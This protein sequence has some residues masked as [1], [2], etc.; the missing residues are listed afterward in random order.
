MFLPKLHPN[1]QSALKIVFATLLLV[2]G[3]VALLHFA[4]HDDVAR[5]AFASHDG[6]DFEIFTANPDGS[7]LVQ[8]TNNDYDDWGATWSPDRQQLA[9]R[10]S[11]NN[12]SG[13]YIMNADGSSV[14]LISA[15]QLSAG[16]PYYQATMTWSPDGTQIAYA[17]NF[18]GNWD[19]W[20]TRLS[21]SRLTRLTSDLGDDLH[22]D[23]SP[24]GTQ[25]AFNR[26]Y[27]GLLEIFVMDADGSNVTQLTKNE[28]GMVM[29]PRWSPDGAEIAFF[30][31]DG[32]FADLFVMNADGTNLRQLTTHIA[33]DRVA[34][35]SPNGTSIVFRSERDG[36]SDI[37]TMNLATG[38]IS[39]VSVNNMMD[40]AP[41]W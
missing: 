40:M 8:I 17:A 20:A 34:A 18:G 22:P 30:I 5:I 31:N 27:N 11:P 41:D 4:P 13:I 33:V 7:D 14:R 2:G 26:Y 15:T 35:F 32:A 39:P 16:N 24:D 36:D 29:Y 38:E 1:T 37:Y 12:M 3:V 25:I 21:D 28:T 9:F 19:I 10:A 23:W 6:N